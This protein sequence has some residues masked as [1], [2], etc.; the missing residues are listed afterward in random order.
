MD[1][2]YQAH[3]LVEAANKKLNPGCWEAL[4]S[5]REERLTQARENLEKAANLFKL[6]KSWEEAGECFERCAGVQEAL[7][8]DPSDFFQD[9]A[10]CFKLNDK[11]RIIIITFRFY[12]EHK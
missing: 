7:K 9:A 8:E 1:Q 10:H 12:T 11:K 2:A 3:L 4:C 5:N 6:E